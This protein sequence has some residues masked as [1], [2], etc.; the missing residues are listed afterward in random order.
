MYKHFT[1]KLRE[2]ITT[3]DSTNYRIEIINEMK[4][5]LPEYN[6]QKYDTTIN[7]LCYLMKEAS[8]SNNCFRT[9]VYE[10]SYEGFKF[11]VKPDIISD[12]LKE[13]LKII[14]DIL[15]N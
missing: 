1:K 7:Y 2:Q 11:D 6:K 3:E 13:Q 9:V 10:L 8:I 5:F 12:R 14:Q 15:E 4:G